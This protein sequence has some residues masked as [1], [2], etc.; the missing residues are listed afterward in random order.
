MICI[1]NKYLMLKIIS[2]TI[3]Y[4]QH[5]KY[6]GR[7]C[8]QFVCSQGAPLLPGRGPSPI[9]GLGGPPV[10]GPGGPQVKFGGYPG[11]PPIVQGVPL[12]S[13]PSSR[14]TL[15]EPPKFRGGYSLGPQ[16]QGGTP[17]APQGHPPSSGGT[18]PQAQGG[19]NFNLP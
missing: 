18:S 11:E 16:V 6:G 9:P 2:H 17:G 8:F 3:Y 10:Q 7:Q 14:G 5:T 12:G 15:A 1:G 19:P 13:P 4:R